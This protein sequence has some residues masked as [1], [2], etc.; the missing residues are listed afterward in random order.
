MRRFA[1][2]M[3]GGL[4]AVAAPAL[5]T[6][7]ISTTFVKV[8][9]RD[10]PLG[11]TVPINGRIGPGLSVINQG[12][13]KLFV[14]VDVLTPT[15]DQLRRGAEPIPDV[16]WLQLIPNTFE[17]EP[18][19]AYTLDAELTVPNKREYRKKHY[20]V[21]IWIHAAPQENQGLIIGGGLLTWMRI[22]TA[23]K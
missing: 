4:L 18:H 5:A 22:K 17:L 21:M 2:I 6:E 1:L 10:V 8:V 15:K 19:E 12:D 23:A 9:A 14:T 3:F 20:Q 7:G 13:V 16:S 11:K